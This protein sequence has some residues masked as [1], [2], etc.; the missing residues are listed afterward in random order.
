[1]FWI[2]ELLIWKYRVFKVCVLRI[3]IGLKLVIFFCKISGH[4]AKR[5]HRLKKIKKNS[6]E[7]YNK[8]FKF[9]LNF[10]IIKRYSENYIKKTKWE[11]Y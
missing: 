6:Q 9:I 1:M 5:Q 11:K 8:N 4:T 7:K 3:Y 10:Q 2:F